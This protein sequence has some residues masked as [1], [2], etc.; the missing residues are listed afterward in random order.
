M[1][2][3]QSVPRLEEERQEE[4]LGRAESREE[5]LYALCGGRPDGEM[6]YMKVMAVAQ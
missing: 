4:K 6:W 5:G 3:G 1:V 2:S